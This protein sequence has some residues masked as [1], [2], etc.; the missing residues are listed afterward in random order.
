VAR[1]ASIGR[2]EARDHGVVDQAAAGGRGRVELDDGGAQPA[3]LKRMSWVIPVSR[4][5][6]LNL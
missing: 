3:S 5:P 6:P 2:I 4:R 1:A